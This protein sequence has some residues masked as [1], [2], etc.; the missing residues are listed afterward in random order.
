MAMMTMTAKGFGFNI[1]LKSPCKFSKFKENKYRYNK[2]IVHSLSVQTGC[3]WFW[4]DKN[5]WFDIFVM[6]GAKESLDFFVPNKNKQTQTSFWVYFWEFFVAFNFLSRHKSSTFFCMII[7]SIQKPNFTWD[8]CSNAKLVTKNELLDAKVNV[9]IGI[10]WAMDCGPAQDL[11]YFFDYHDEL[12]WLH[13]S[14]HLFTLW[15][16]WSSS[17]SNLYPFTHLIWLSLKIESKLAM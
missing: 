12:N 3:C 13:L 6:C 10:R 8:L 9:D 16:K 2:Y 14:I 5:S 1:I 7:N 4:T 15:L 11:F 17:S